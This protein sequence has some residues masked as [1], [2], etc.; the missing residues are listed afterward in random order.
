MHLRFWRRNPM[1]P[2]NIDPTVAP[3]PLIESDPVEPSTKPRMGIG[4]AQVSRSRQEADARI[5]EFDPPD[6][7]LPD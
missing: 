2:L 1:P 5:S 6:K 4:E 3:T 7:P